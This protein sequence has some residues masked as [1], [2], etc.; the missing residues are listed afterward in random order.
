MRIIWAALQGVCADIMGRMNVKGYHMYCC[1]RSS[2]SFLFYFSVH[3]LS[4][5]S[6]VSHELHALSCHSLTM[7]GQASQPSSQI[8]H[9]TLGPKPHYQPTLWLL[10]RT[11][12]QLLAI[13]SFKLPYL[14]LRLTSSSHKNSIHLLHPP[15]PPHLPL[16]NCNPHQTPL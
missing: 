10:A 1:A 8:S 6:R 14:Q 16:I 5:I 13:S 12:M 4:S 3:F 2:S 15:T 11:L 9:I 7:E